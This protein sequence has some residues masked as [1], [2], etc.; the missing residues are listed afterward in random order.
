MNFPRPMH[1]WDG[2]DD[3]CLRYRFSRLREQYDQAARRIDTLATKNKDLRKRLAAAEKKKHGPHPPP[4]G[5]RTASRQG[6]TS[7]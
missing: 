2:S 1:L 4:D 7:G 6:S 5:P 3:G